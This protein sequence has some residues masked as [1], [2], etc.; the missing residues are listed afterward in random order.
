MPHRA[1]DMGRS[2]LCPLPEC[3]EADTSCWICL[4]DASPENGPLLS[5]CA[6]PR[7]CHRACLAK[8]QLTSAGRR[9]VVA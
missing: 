3:D 7:K 8:W 9:C 4:S 6:C 1:D 5:P 2:T